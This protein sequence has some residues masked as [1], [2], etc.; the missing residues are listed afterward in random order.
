MHQGIQAAFGKFLI[1]ATF[2]VLITTGGHAARIT[3]INSGFWDSGSTWD[4]GSVPV[5]G[6]TIIIPAGLT[7]TVRTQIDYG[8]NN[9]A[10]YLSISGNLTF[11]TGKKI[12]FPCNSVVALQT[13][14]SVVPGNGGGSS[15]YIDICGTVVWNAGM[16]TEVGPLV[17]SLNPLPVEWL[18]VS[19][20]VI[21]GTAVE[22]VWSTLSEVNNDYFT[23]EHSPDGKKFEAVAVVDGHGTTSQPNYYR[24]T[25]LKPYKG[26][27]YYQ[28]R[29]TD[30][31]GKFFL[32]KMYVISITKQT[33]QTIIYPN[34]SPGEL[35]VKH[36]GGNSADP[37]DFKIYSDCGI[38]IGSK[39]RIPFS[40]GQFTPITDHNTLPSGKYTVVITNS[41]GSRSY[42]VIIQKQ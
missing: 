30:F 24:V 40:N 9:A 6:D 20:N 16:G 15:N 34:P 17:W 38:L 18:D 3:C 4:R 14:G 33:V 23:V 35:L 22:I 32:S 11:Q 31:D 12:S 25:D 42:P 21:N 5:P 28:I 41:E 36:E 2:L 37:W 26:T 10:M 39:S 13:G 1:L 8:V 27:S 29:Q 19:V 7:V